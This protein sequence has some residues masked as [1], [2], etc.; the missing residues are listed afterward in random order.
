MFKK[1]WKQRIAFLT[2]ISAKTFHVMLYSL[3]YS[4]IMLLVLFNGV[5]WLKSGVR[6][7]FSLECYEYLLYK[8]LELTGYAQNC[9]KCEELKE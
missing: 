3:F 7:A 8:G 6:I 2:P 5:F 1:H 4:H 9:K